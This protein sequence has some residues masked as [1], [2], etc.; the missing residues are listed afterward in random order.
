MSTTTLINAL[1][2]PPDARL[3]QR[4]P[5]KL[6]LEQGAPTAADK[7]HLQD[8]IEEIVFRYQASLARTKPAA[9]CGGYW[10]QARDV[11]L[12]GVRGDMAFRDRS[13]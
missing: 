13:L 9:E 11:L 12:L 10:R 1:A 6:L 5:K 4:V 2:L 3:D 8:G 7:R